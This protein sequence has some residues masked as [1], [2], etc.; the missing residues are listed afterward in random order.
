ME[1]VFDIP[2]IQDRIG[3]FL[4][5][6]SVANCLRVSKQFQS[7][8]LPVFW[9][10]TSIGRS[11]HSSLPEEHH[12]QTYS[13]SIRQLSLHGFVP[14]SNVF[15]ST[16]HLAYISL[17][18]KLGHPKKSDSIWALYTTLILQSRATLKT[19]RLSTLEPAPS[20]GFWKALTSDTHSPLTRL[21]H[22]QVEDLSFDSS[23]IA[24][25]FW[26]VCERI[27]SLEIENISFPWQDNH[28]EDWGWYGMGLVHQ[29]PSEKATT[30]NSTT[31]DATLSLLSPS[32]RFAQ[33]KALRIQGETPHMKPEDLLM[34]LIAQAPELRYLSWVLGK[35][36][37][38]PATTFHQLAGKDQTW[39][40]LETIQ[41]QSPKTGNIT[42][43]CIAA[44]LSSLLIVP[45]SAKGQ[46]VGLEN[47][48]HGLREL[49]VSHSGFG[50][51]SMSALVRAHGSAL[52]RTIEVLDVQS[53][54][55]VPS[56]M[57]QQLLESCPRLRILRATT[58]SI[59]DI[60][61]GEP[62]V[63]DDLRE[64]EVQLHVEVVQDET[65]DQKQHN[66]ADVRARLRRLTLLNKC[67][68]GIPSL[69]EG[70]SWSTSARE[71]R[72][73]EAESTMKNDKKVCAKHTKPTEKEDVV[74][75]V[76][77]ES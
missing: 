39:R 28:D 68:L 35:D 17:S 14:Q 6:S 55:G 58:L 75:A 36:D 38:F 47:E 53:C 2:E 3:Y 74:Y 77:T 56:W 20:E 62:W 40:K 54:S 5:P 11:H 30:A 22:L 57:V 18:G 65:E 31:A 15:K 19:I 25:L 4:C 29:E 52:V 60:V 69:L 71:P 73:L 76:V 72:P 50:N 67:F 49:R 12:L 16:R 44:V 41:L 51:E 24:Q 37:T 64:M 9:H 43:P 66:Y 1:A 32:P 8:F 34:T 33:L 10:T 27:E 21:K 46:R 45:P 63:C 42:D 59:Q 13:S 61:Q 26:Q 48:H 23:T 70:S 7:W